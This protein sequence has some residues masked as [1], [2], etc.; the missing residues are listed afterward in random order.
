MSSGGDRGCARKCVEADDSAGSG[1]DRNCEDTIQGDRPVAVVK[2]PP[3][4][5]LFPVGGSKEP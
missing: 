4:D 5:T 3:P 2:V 1:I